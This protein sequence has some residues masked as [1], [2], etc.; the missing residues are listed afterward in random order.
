M[1]GEGILAVKSTA[2]KYIKG[3]IDLTIRKRPLL[4]LLNQYGRLMF[5]SDPSHITKWHVQIR[6]PEV[7][8]FGDSQRQVFLEH[9][10]YEQLQIENAAYIA[11]DKLPLLANNVNSGANA[12]V[13]H[14]D[15]K[16]PILVKAATHRICADTFNDGSTGSTN[17][18][19]GLRTAMQPDGSV[20]ANDLIA[21]PAS[22]AAYGGKSCQLGAFGG[23]WSSDMGTAP[24]SVLSNDWPYGSG[25]PEYDALAPKMFNYSS[26]RWAS[27]QTGFED[28]VLEILSLA[29]TTTKSLGGDGSEPMLHMLCTE[30]Y[31][32]FQ[33]AL[34]AKERII[35]QHQEGADYGFPNVLNYE[36]ALVNYDFDVPSQKG[37]GMNIQE[38]SLYTL[39]DDLFF[40]EG[41]VWNT[42]AQAYLFVVGFHGNYRFSSFK[43]FCEYGS[44]GS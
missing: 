10:A 37:Y 19:A 22:T 12:I 2:P 44:Y 35:L 7:R 4:G 29:K 15:E 34:K 1:A 9:D 36:G 30:F 28:N 26:N 25:D 23:T 40:S 33:N 21:A 13:R 14:Y 8:E 38:M 11:T 3:A 24:S 27:G 17:R 5:G 39:T 16:L 32:G 18:L 20:D 31:H 41:P 43:H 42:E 6:E